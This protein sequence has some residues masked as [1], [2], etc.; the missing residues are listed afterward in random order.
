[1]AGQKEREGPVGPSRFDQPCLRATLRTLG[2]AAGEHLA[3]A[4]EV[5]SR[6]TE[7][8]GSEE[9]HRVGDV[10]LAVLVEIEG[11]YAARRGA[12]GELEAEAVHRIGDVQ[13]G[14]A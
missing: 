14:I 3:L 5:S 6:N 10:E 11:R 7:E 9:G 8:Q 1:M 12:A 4:E 2:R 13:V